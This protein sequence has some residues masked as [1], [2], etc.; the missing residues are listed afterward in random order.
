[1]GYWTNV[2]YFY[3]AS[4]GTTL[5]KYDAT[6]ATMVYTTGIGNTYSAG[7]A[8]IGVLNAQSALSG[9]SKFTTAHTHDGYPTLVWENDPNALPGFSR[10]SVKSGSAI[11][12]PDG[13]YLDGTAATDGAG[14][15]SDPCNSFSTAIGYAYNQSKQLYIMGQVTLTA[16]DELNLAGGTYSGMTIKRAVG[17]TGYLFECPSGVTAT[18]SSVTIDG[19]KEN[20]IATSSLINVTGGS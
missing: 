1:V 6:D 11:V 17:Y 2:G 16:S 7:S 19:N 8:P 14:T 10:T 18:V 4:E 15:A 20:V 12:Y 13:I 3:N 5:E 9:G